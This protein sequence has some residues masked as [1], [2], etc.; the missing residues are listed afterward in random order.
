ME[1][2]AGRRSS[3]LS[4]TR[5]FTTTPGVTHPAVHISRRLAMDSYEGFTTE[6]EISN[7]IAAGKN[8][9]RSQ[10]VTYASSQHFA[11][12]FVSITTGLSSFTS[13]SENFSDLHLDPSS[14]EGINAYVEAFDN[15]EGNIDSADPAWFRQ[16]RGLPQGRQNATA[17]GSA[18]PAK[19]QP[20]AS[21]KGCCYHY[22]GV[23]V[24]FVDDWSP[25]MS[26]STLPRDWLKGVNFL[27]RLVEPF[28]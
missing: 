1:P 5:P 27:H 8:T 17:E 14:V 6:D 9:I 12:L 28:T 18:S 13:M 26:A 21:Q 22:L 7:S 20:C 19:S 24:A 23:N 25:L 10:Y 15:D 4:C 11:L 16:E 3:H 2:T